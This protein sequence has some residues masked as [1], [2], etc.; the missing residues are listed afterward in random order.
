MLD[1]LIQLGAGVM[2]VAGVVLA[3]WALFWD[4]PRGRPRCPKCWYDM[5]GAIGFICPECGHDARRDR[6]LFKTRRRLAWAAAGLALLPA[7]AVLHATPKVQQRAELVTA[8]T[9]IPPTDWA[10]L[11]GWRYG[12]LAGVPSSVLVAI[13]PVRED[14]WTWRENM[15]TSGSSIQWAGEQYNERRSDM[16]WLPR[17]PEPR[18]ALLKEAVRR[19]NAHELRAWQSQVFLDRFYRRHPEQLTNLFAAPDRWPR[20]RPIAIALGSPLDNWNLENVTVR[21]TLLGTGAMPVERGASHRCPYPREALR[22]IA[23]WPP[24]G[25]DL[26][27]LEVIVVAQ[28]EGRNVGPGGRQTRYVDGVRLWRGT[29]RIQIVDSLKTSMIPVHLDSAAFDPEHFTALLRFSHG[30]ATVQLGLKRSLLE[31]LDEMAIGLNVE[32]LRDGV[33]VAQVPVCSPENNFAR[34]DPRWDPVWYRWLPEWQVEPPASQAE[35]EAHEWT[36]RLSPDVAVA[37]RNIW[38]TSYWADSIELPI[39]RY[40]IPRVRRYD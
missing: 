5:A 18:H 31:L 11:W 2:A 20:D 22:R 27:D 3:A 40:V 38:K 29:Q 33:P 13:A 15:M 7:A 8:R 16:S 37:R 34:L 24:L 30:R 25:G 14:A 23:G 1:W 21:A 28:V 35:F 39:Q 6:R 4:R 26:V 36:L 17:R 12:W 9:G 32:V 19:L 10:A